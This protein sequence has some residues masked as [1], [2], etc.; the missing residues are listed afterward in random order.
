MMNGSKP[1]MKIRDKIFPSAFALVVQ[2]LAAPF[3]KRTRLVTNSAPSSR[4]SR[5]ERILPRRNT[6]SASALQT[7]EAASIYVV[8]D[9][10]D[11][12]EWY[13]T[14][15]EATGYIVR[16][17]NDR[18]EALA[19]LQADRTKPDLLITDY[20]GLGL[21]MRVDQFIHHCLVVHPTLRILMASGCSQTDMRFSQARPD[22]FI[23][24]PFT[25]EEFRQAVRA[26]LTAC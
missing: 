20:L 8:D 2:A 14:L 5:S 22:R 15:L 1:G 21:S 26:A 16:A 24:K 6:S 13:T 10:P 23:E 7:T 19:A 18:T 12:T 4:S 9:L 25:P 3:L 17:F 11:L